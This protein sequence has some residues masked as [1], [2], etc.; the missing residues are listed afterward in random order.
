MKLKLVG[1]DEAVV[2][3]YKTNPIVFLLY[4]YL[5]QMHIRK[6]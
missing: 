6:N 2:L 3:L 1:P 4:C 5:R